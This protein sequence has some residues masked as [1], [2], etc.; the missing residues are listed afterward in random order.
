MPFQ[1]VAGHVQAAVPSCRGQIR[2]LRWPGEWG[3]E[4]GVGAWAG[5]GG[6]FQDEGR[7]RE[8]LW[9]A[10]P[11]NG[12]VLGHILPLVPDLIHP[13]WPLRFTPVILL[14]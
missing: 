9:G 4:T 5:Q 1:G 2:L 7:E 14:I 8:A 13:P 12:T 6:P 10:Q 11:G 3:K